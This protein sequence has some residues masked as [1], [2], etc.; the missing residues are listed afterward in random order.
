MNT[1][2]FCGQPH[3][4][5]VGGLTAWG[6]VELEPASPEFDGVAIDECFGE[7]GLG[8]ELGC[9]RFDVHERAPQGHDP[10]HV[11]R[12]QVAPV[13]AHVAMVRLRDRLDAVRIEQAPPAD[14]VGMTLGEG[15]EPQGTGAGSR[16][17]RLDL[18]RFEVSAGVDQHV[19]I[20]GG[21]QVAVRDVLGHEDA[22]AHVDRILAALAL[23]DEFVERWRH[24]RVHL[25]RSASA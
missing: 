11:E 14:V 23:F 22:V 15:D 6:G 3:H 21:D 13:F 18:G 12:M 16:E 17:T 25:S 2:R 9:V 7:Y 10:A 1:V 20:G 4:E 19:A 8:W 24:R 5:R